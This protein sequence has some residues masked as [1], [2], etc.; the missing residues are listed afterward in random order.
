MRIKIP[1][2]LQ[3]YE[4]RSLPVNAQEL[5]NM[6]PEVQPQ[7]SKSNPVVLPSPGSTLYITVG[8]GPIH[9][10]IVKG[11]VLYAVSGEELYSVTNGTSTLLGTITG[12]MR[13][14]MAHNGD[15]VCIVNGTKGYIYDSTTSTLS[16]ITDTAFY[17]TNRV[18]YMERRFVFPRTGTPQFFCSDA[19]DGTSYDGLNFDQV[20]NNRDDVVSMI[21]DHGEIWIFTSVGAEVWVYN[22][23]ETAFPFSR[24]DGAYV[25][26]GCY[27]AHSPAKMDNTFYWLGSDLKIYRSDGYKPTRISSHAIENAIQNY[28]DPSTATGLT[29]EYL[30][31]SFYEISFDEAT[32]RFDAATNRWHEGRFGNERYHSNAT[33]RFN[34][35]IIIGDRRNGNIYTLEKTGF[36]DQEPIIRIASSPQIHSGRLRAVMDRLDVDLDMGIGKTTGQG[37]DPQMMMTY[38]NDGGRTWSSERWKTMGSR[39]EYGKRVRYPQ[40]GMFYQR[41]FKLRISDP[42]QPT[43]ID[44]YADVEA[45]D[46]Y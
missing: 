30:G 27:A 45:D 19:F 10:M 41:I 3:A 42:V 20:L 2:G 40:L 24:I 35:E 32:W 1:F 16:E 12:N 25:E 39:G 23:N 5:V 26:K 34:K 28:N 9:G 31:H 44:A 4:S 21:A 33:V 17:P 18:V 22:R 43:I 38:S 46:A 11:G 6:F 14:D 8:V 36:D 29:Y 13:V 7:D 15:Q 37:S